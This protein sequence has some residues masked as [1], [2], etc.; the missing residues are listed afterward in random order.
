MVILPRKPVS[1]NNRLCWC[2]GVVFE[3]TLF[4]L[5]ST[6]N[7]TLCSTLLFHSSST[8]PCFKN[9]LLPFTMLLKIS[10]RKT[11]LLLCLNPWTRFHLL[12]TMF[13]VL[14]PKWYLHLPRVHVPILLL[15][16][17]FSHCLSLATESPPSA[18][19]ACW[20]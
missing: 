1:H 15:S 16:F 18:L 5:K 9:F 17:C 19:H 14:S 11:L 10:P 2:F 20:P 8:T 6:V 7:I 13:K 12:M 4:Q 3:T